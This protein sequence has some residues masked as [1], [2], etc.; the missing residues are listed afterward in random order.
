MLALIDSDLVAF[1]CAASAENEPEDIAILRVDKL[2]RDI[3]EA[4]EA[5]EYLAFLTG[6]GN[7]RKQINPEYKANR[8]DQPLPIHLKAC[9]DFL[10]QEWNAQA[11]EGV[12]ADDALGIEQWKYCSLP[13]DDFGNTHPDFKHTVICSLDKDM[14]QVP[15]MHY[16]WPIYNREG[17]FHQV[18]ELDGLKTFYRQM[19]EGDTSDNVKGVTGIGKVKAAKLIDH[20]TTE[21]EMFNTVCK[22]Y[23]DADRFQMNLDCL[24]IMRNPN[25]QFTDRS[26]FGH[27]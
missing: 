2:M 26:I 12:E 13:I 4:V 20:L 5:E 7:F 3:L 18:F 14:L 23:N 27:S 24:W 16:Q 11:T 15:G 25:E 21:K 6:P 17:R 8:K 9:K 1:R 19:L 10:I 22:L